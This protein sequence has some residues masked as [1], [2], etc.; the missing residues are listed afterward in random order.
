MVTRELWLV[1]HRDSRRIGRIRAF[2]DHFTAEIQGQAASL[3]GDEP[4]ATPIAAGSGSA[5][6]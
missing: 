4:A 6:P 2:V 3:L 5:R 1:L